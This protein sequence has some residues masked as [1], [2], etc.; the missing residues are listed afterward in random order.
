MGTRIWQKR[1]NAS[2]IGMVVSWQ[3]TPAQLRFQ[4]MLCSWMV[5]MHVEKMDGLWSWMVE[6]RRQN[7]GV[8]WTFRGLEKVI[9]HKLH[10]NLVFLCICK[11]NK[12]N[13]KPIQLKDHFTIS[14]HVYQL[15]C[16]HI[17][18][19]PSLKVCHVWQSFLHI[20]QLMM[21]PTLR[22]R[23]SENMKRVLPLEVFRRSSKIVLFVW[24]SRYLSYRIFCYWVNEDLLYKPLG[25]AWKR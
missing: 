17:L 22:N 16:F 20:C 11:Q 14:L 12:T 8:A 4:A 5:Y 13:L 25:D 23:F 1:L 10:F 3:H 19:V 15:W 9:W 6:G 24:L 18:L 21:A 2:L 7:P